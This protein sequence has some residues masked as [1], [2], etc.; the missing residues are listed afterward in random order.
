MNVEPWQRAEMPGPKRS[1]VFAKPEVVVTMVKTAKRPILIVGHETLENGLGEEK[2]IDY[3][4]QMAETAGMP[5]IATA[6]IFGE[7]VKR[8]FK[9]AAWMSLM[10]ITN[11]LQ[12]PE[13]K[14]LDGMGQYDLALF[15]GFP[16][17]MQWVIL[18]SL[19]HASPDL[20]TV[21]LDRFYHPHATCSFPNSSLEYWI[22]CLKVIIGELEAK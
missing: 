12:D 13:W 5:V 6:H 14:G 16:Y 8:G 19:K 17:Y 10:D 7:F 18:S 21:N 4:I 15:M 20:K 9:P 11:R 22:K 1:L 2:I 3:V